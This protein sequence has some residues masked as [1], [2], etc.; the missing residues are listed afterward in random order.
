MIFLLKKKILKKLK[1]F[2][3]SYSKVRFYKEKEPVIYIHLNH[4]TKVRTYLNLFFRIRS[5]YKEPIVIKFSVLRMIFLAKW[6]KNLDYIYFEVP[7]SNNKKAKVFSHKKNADFRI[8]Y[9]YKKI[10]SVNDFQEN[11]LPYIMHPG[12]YMQREVNKLPKKAGILMS[13]NFEEKIYNTKTIKSNFGLLNRWEI[14]QEVIKYN[15]L[16]SISGTDF[17]N[18][19]DSNRFDGKFVLMKWQSGAIPTHK[20]RHYLSA[21]DFIFCAPGM[22]MPMCHNVLEAMPV[23]V[24]PILNYPNWLNPSLQNGLIV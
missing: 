16:I 15:E 13:G 4:Q 20:W 5:V 1:E 8:N 2:K 24:I 21:T 9:N 23:G 22:T 14:Y 18:E 17:V 10:Y 6:F 12:N 19:L 11:T 7:F 3:E